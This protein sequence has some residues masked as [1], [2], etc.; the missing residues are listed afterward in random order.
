M[1]IT[2]DGSP[3]PRLT[4]PFKS[5]SSKSQGVRCP[6]HTPLGVA[7][8]RSRST[9]T[10]KL[11]SVATTNPLPYMLRPVLQIC[12]LSVLSAVELRRRSR[13][14]G[15]LLSSQPLTGGDS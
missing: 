4:L 15:I 5:V 1:R 10:D 13:F 2:D 6:L 8:I 12:H 9:R 3:V 7:K 11:P 14:W